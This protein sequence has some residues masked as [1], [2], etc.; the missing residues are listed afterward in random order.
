[1]YQ[2][3]IIPYFYE[4]RHVSGHT[5]QHQEPKTALAASEFHTWKVVWTCSSGITATRRKGPISE[6]KS[7]RGGAVVICELKRSITPRR[8]TN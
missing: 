2:N 5:A 8:T 6:R 3:F 7:A 1:M 4:A